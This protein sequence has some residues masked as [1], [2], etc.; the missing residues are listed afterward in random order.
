[1]T[2]SLSDGE[3]FYII[4]NG[5]RFTGMPAWGSDPAEHEGHGES[6]DQKDNWELVQF[7]RHLPKIT[8]DELE[9]MARLSPQSAAEAEEESH[10]GEFLE[11]GK[12]QAPTTEHSHHHHHHHLEN[13]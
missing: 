9:E 11:G 3:L 2:Q 8:R 13:R 6:H 10:E 12:P 5:V 4:Q 7:I 1:R